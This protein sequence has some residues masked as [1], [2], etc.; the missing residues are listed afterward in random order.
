MIYWITGRRN[1]GKTTLAYNLQKELRSGQGICSLVI[2][3]DV[4]RKY[5]PEGFEF[6]DRVE[7]VKRMIRIAKVAEEQGL[8]PIIAA[9]TPYKSMRDFGRNAFKDF[10]LIYIPGGELWEGTEYEEPD[11]EELGENFDYVEIKPMTIKVPH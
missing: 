11:E 8:I 1:A 7:H 2:D 5:F 6:Y 10:R 9:V 3:G 4:I